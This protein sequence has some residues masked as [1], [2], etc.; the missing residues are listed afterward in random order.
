MKK[1]VTTLL[2]L[3]GIGI[4]ALSIWGTKWGTNGEKKPVGGEGFIWPDGSKHATPYTGEP[5]PIKDGISF[6]WPDGTFHTNPYVAPQPAPDGYTWADGTIHSTP[7][8][9]N[10]Q[11]DYGDPNANTFNT[12]VVGPQPGSAM[13][14]IVRMMN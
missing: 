11:V 6:Q 10:V 3:S 1:T 14:G 9:I 2:V 8:N 4:V 13:G 5:T 12:G 7:S